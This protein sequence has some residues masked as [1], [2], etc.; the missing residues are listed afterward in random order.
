MAGNPFDRFD[1]PFDIF[2]ED[3]KGPAHKAERPGVL[4]EYGSKLRA[5]FERG[6]DVIGEAFADL[7][8][9]RSDDTRATQEQVSR[10]LGYRD[11]DDMLGA[12]RA[13]RIAEGERRAAQLDVTHPDTARGLEEIQRADSLGSAIGAAVRNPRAVGAVTAESFGAFAPAMVAGAA[14]GPAMPAAL[15]AGSFAMEYGSA[16]R[17]TL[18]EAGV[19]LTDRAQVAR[20][21][22]NPDLMQRAR[23]RGV[24]RGVPVAAFDALS[25][26]LAGR[27]LH[28]ARGLGSGA[29]RSAGEVGVQ[30]GSGMA[31]EALG[32]IAA[33]GGVSQWGDVALEGIAEIPTGVPEAAS[34]LYRLRDRPR[35]N[36]LA[37]EML[38]RS[39]RQLRQG[40][41]D[42]IQD[43]ASTTEQVRS[44][45]E[46]AQADYRDL[47]ERHGATITSL[48][49]TPENNRRVGGVPNS[50]HTRGTAGDFV[51]PA[52][53]KAD[54]IADARR[55]GYE[56][57]DEGDHVHLE[58]PPSR[59][60]GQSAAESALE[61]SRRSRGLGPDG[62]SVPEV[63]SSPIEIST[64]EIKPAD[65]P[66]PLPGRSAIDELIE[67]HRQA[68]STYSDSS[69]PAPVRREA[70]S[71]SQQLM[72][73]IERLR[74]Q[75]HRPQQVSAIEQELRR[76][77]D[78][79]AQQSMQSLAPPAQQPQVSP[80]PPQAPVEAPMTAPAPQ[81]PM[82]VPAEPV[83]QEAVATPVETAPPQAPSQSPAMP[84]AAP[85][86]TVPTEPQPTPIR[87]TV[88][89]GTGRADRGSVYNGTEVPILGEG[90]YYAND[91]ETASQFGPNVERAEIEL[92]TP[93]VIESDEQW[94]R[95]TR[96]AGWRT[97]NPQGLP[98]DEVAQATQ[99]LQRIIRS[100]GHDGIIVEF[101][102]NSPYDIVEGR[103]IKLLRNV[104]GAPQVLVFDPPPA[105]A[106][107]ERPLAVVQK[108]STPMSRSLTKV[109]DRHPGFRRA[110]GRPN[111][112]R[113]GD[114]M[115]AR[116]AP[117]VERE[118]RRVERL[119]GRRIVPIQFNTPIPLNV[120]GLA[121][122]TKHIF[123]NVRAVEAERYNLLGLVG[124][125]FTHT[126]RKEGNADLDQLIRYAQAQINRDNSYVQSTFRGYRD[127]Y[128]HMSPDKFED[129]ITEE[130]IADMIG[131]MLADEQFWIELTQEE[132]SLARRLLQRFIAFLEALA[133]R[134][135]KMGD[136]D[137][138]RNIEALRKRAKEIVS[139]H[140]NAVTQREQ[141][142]A[143]ESSSSADTAASM[144]MT[145]EEWDAAEFG[146]P[147]LS[148]GA[149]LAR[150]P[151]DKRNLNS[152]FA[153][154]FPIWRDMK[155]LWSFLLHDE[156]VDL[157]D[158]QQEIADTYFDGRLPEELDAWGNE[159]LRHGAYQDARR[160]AET[161]FIAPIAR[162][163]SNAGISLDEFS[164]YLWWRHAP[165][166]DAYLRQHLDPELAEQVPP[167]GLAGIDPAEAQRNIAALPPE[168][169][170][171]MERAAKFVDGMRRFTLEVMVRSGQISAEHRDNLLKQYQFYVPLRG[172]DETDL[173]DFNNIGTAR[174][175]RMPKKPLGPRAAGRVTEPQNILEE[176]VRDMENALVN[177][178]KHKVLESLIK[179]IVTHPD[180]DLWE[181]APMS[182][183][184]RWVNGVLTVVPDRGD[185]DKQITFMHHGIPVAI[186]I[187]HKRLRH[188]LLNMNQPAD[189]VM[190]YIAKI[191]RFLS[192]SK[193]AFSPYFLLANPVRDMQMATAA[194][195]S[196]HGAGAMADFTRFYPYT[197]VALERDAMR[198][199]K[200]ASDPF[201]QKVMQ[202]AR[203]FAA[204]GGKTG[205]T[206]VSDIREQ[207]RNLRRLI[208]RYSESKGMSDLLAGNFGTK[209]AALL[210][211]KIGQN[212]L[213][214]FEVVNDMAENS[215]RLA[216]Y[217][218][219]REKGMS[220]HEAAKYAKEVTVN[221]NRRGMLARYLGPLYMFYNAAMQGSVR[222]IK[223]MR[224]PK[225]AA[226]MLSGV[227]VNYALVLAQ[228]FA[229]GDD[230]DGES[231]YEKAVPDSQAR[232]YI[233]IHLGDDRS[234]TIPVAY[235]PNIFTYLGHRLA[236]Y[237]YELVKGKNPKFGEMIGDVLSQAASAL[238]PIDPGKGPQALLPEF[239][240]IFKQAGDNTNDFGGKIAPGRDPFNDKT[241]HF[242]ETD[243]RTHGIFKMIAAGLNYASGG[244]DYEP[245]GINWTGEQVRYVAQQLTGGMGR[246][247]D[248]SLSLWKKIDADIPVR[249]SDIPLANVYYRGKGEEGRH[250]GTFY[251]N[252]DT[253]ENLVED[254]KLAVERGDQRTLERIYRE[255]PWIEGV[256][257]PANTREGKAVQAGTVHETIREIQREMRRV[258]QQ[259][260][261]IAVDPNLTS[262]QKMQAAQQLQEYEAQLQQDYNYALNVARGYPSV[263]GSR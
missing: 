11:A 222:L 263:L 62:I 146:D 68:L 179:L 30:A 50:Q 67:R 120:I 64:P 262:E 106:F 111:G 197:Y 129:A 186:E 226:F 162:T 190:Q 216:A 49:R 29:L 208:D 52:E 140:I 90:T 134:A 257:V 1:N 63:D 210:L 45:R 242:N 232:R 22:Q 248:E 253:Y 164:R 127:L 165:E 259:K 31:G 189:K 173:I 196:E 132:P 245:G 256:E 33:D 27:L 13:T 194:I 255:A 114:I 221:F 53:R 236:K 47:A 41:F 85:A 105:P 218:A 80:A 92:R 20:A 200:Q 147:G 81:P 112:L 51:V 79:V 169:R 193:T 123:I 215:T 212:V 6:R 143:Q 203:E 12:E 177:E 58:L 60:R 126:L 26:G 107:P 61:Q 254:W 4:E 99:R 71:L 136:D 56:A 211:R 43:G 108:V 78:S 87:R 16:M 117:E 39:N 98:A 205:Y 184:R 110:L 17:D 97:P 133:R 44:P 238:S 69:Q 209:D 131:D 183:K 88:Y 178:Q 24:A 154:Q 135:R 220:V 225:F 187:R 121:G 2:D 95:L 234:I 74:E 202:Y 70:K 249:A 116:L 15:G 82:T 244:T 21:L 86:E 38:E 243:P 118:L 148:I 150:I 73:Q 101:D 152:M 40:A 122:D 65:V 258:G 3:Y 176:M 227:A 260:R 155:K 161:R 149:A 109:L 138:F 168:K 119:L 174:G 75:G 23:E 66:A 48:D 8:D 223:L 113:S 91:E 191:T 76:T 25:A 7:F 160:R 77:L 59:S 137:A 185:A 188:A 32:Q 231:R 163:L 214:G 14:T 10:G 159:N 235:G 103:G 207:Q 228:M 151:P 128:A 100:R 84:P 102:K 37:P 201:L 181:I 94:R 35:G 156:F 34:N 96:E 42:D 158:I 124:H 9:L 18:A 250:A 125:E 224:N 261:A 204:M 175:L 142:V 219:M 145:P 233:S 182:A 172:K 46:A 237:H 180:P 230:D 195:L 36:E 55:R 28:G 229:A 252:R 115:E 144:G 171:A 83:P 153:A 241:P 206:Y 167:N 19:D 199:P 104:F 57:I 247:L 246:L 240:R 251:D 5:G 192:A 72:Q 141:G 54:F 217:A 157:R 93:L 130:L 213:A 89:R 198:H 139:S 170:R 166:R 239:V